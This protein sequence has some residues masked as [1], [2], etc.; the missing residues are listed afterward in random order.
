MKVEIVG[1]LLQNGSD[2]FAPITI[3]E[4][5]GARTIKMPVSEDAYK[6]RGQEPIPLSLLTDPSSTIKPVEVEVRDGLWCF[7]NKIFAVK[8]SAGISAEELQIRIKH[9]L[10]NAEKQFTKMKKE[11]ELFENFDKVVASRREKIPESIRLFVWQRDEGK[12]VQCGSNKKL[13]YDHIIP[14][15]KGGS[16]TERN[17]QILC[18]ECNR[19]K[20]A[21]I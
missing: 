2:W 10:L 15:A 5:P 20:A 13:E 9:K 8:G 14:V 6:R 21:S 17:L 12:C 4:G 3:G 11:I 18:E 19:K 1:S 16:N 7:Q